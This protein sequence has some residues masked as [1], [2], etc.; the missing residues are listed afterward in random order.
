MCVGDG[1]KSVWSVYLTSVLSSARGGF[2][3]MLCYAMLCNPSFPSLLF[4]FSVPGSWAQYQ[5]TK[6]PFQLKLTQG[7]NNL[8]VLIR[9]GSLH[10][11]RNRIANLGVVMG[12][13]Q[14]WGMTHPYKAG[15]LL[16]PGMKM[17]VPT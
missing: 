10:I 16:G 7:N 3:A 8:S 5:K 17:L 14:A 6:H 9:F 4:L 2:M 13:R 11:Y 12:I 1:W 15:S